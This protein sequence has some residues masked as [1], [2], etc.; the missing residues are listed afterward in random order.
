MPYFFLRH[1]TKNEP[2]VFVSNL[3]IISRPENN[4]P[5]QL[6]LQVVW[7]NIIIENCVRCGEICMEKNVTIFHV[8][9]AFSAYAVKHK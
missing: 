8:S 7:T 9:V 6:T 2:L 3:Q 5:Q 1:N 4:F